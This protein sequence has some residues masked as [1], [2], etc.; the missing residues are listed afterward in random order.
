MEKPFLATS[1]KGLK[2]APFGGSFIFSGVRHGKTK[3][4]RRVERSLEMR[5]SKVPLPAKKL[6]NMKKKQNKIMPAGVQWTP[7]H[8]PEN[9]IR[10]RLEK[11][12]VYYLNTSV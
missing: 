2:T 8:Y 3:P 7:H 6:A 12:S 9:Q 1:N 11:S 5:N 4:I 10:F